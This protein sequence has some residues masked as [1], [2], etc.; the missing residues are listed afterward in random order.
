[1][2]VGAAASAWVIFAWLLFCGRG[3]QS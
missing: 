3:F 1:M 2:V